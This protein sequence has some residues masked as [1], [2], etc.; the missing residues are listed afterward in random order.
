MIDIIQKIKPLQPI[1]IAAG[2]I[3]AFTFWQRDSIQ[4]Q[5]TMQE[6]LRESYNKETL[7][8]EELQELR[9]RIYNLELKINELLGK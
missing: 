5:Q 9:L 4:S 8:Q 2:V 1:I 7:C 6:L 3:I